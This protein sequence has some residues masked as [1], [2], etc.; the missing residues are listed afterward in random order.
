MASVPFSKFHPREVHS[1][2][3]AVTELCAPF[4]ES[5]PFL[6][7]YLN[8]LEP[9]VAGLSQSIARESATDL[10]EQAVQEDFSF[11]RN[12]KEL[13]TLA[14]VKAEIEL[15]GDEA[16]ACSV[17]AK[18]ISDHGGRIEDFS[19]AVQI[20]T[21]DSLLA[22]WAVESFQEVINKAVVRP[23]YESVVDTHEALKQ[24]ESLRSTASANSEEI[25]SMWKAKSIVSPLLSKIYRH[26]EDFAA[27]DSVQY[28]ELLIALDAKLAPITTQVRSRITRK[29]AE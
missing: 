2:S 28:G 20:T 9:T 13:R 14:E 3:E 22:K 15:L 25:L 1:A 17:I 24:T 8:S 12:F 10:T 29:S 5:N 19:R 18:S 21:M 27:I 6:A 26:I 4:I 11:D 7:G 16:E 23:L